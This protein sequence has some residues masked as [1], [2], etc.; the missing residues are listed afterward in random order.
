MT[1]TPFPP[2][3]P[4]A[5]PL[6]LTRAGS[7]LIGAAVVLA[8]LSGP[9]YR[10]GLANLRVALLA[11]ALG[12]VV[13]F[14]GTVLA[15][16]GLTVASARRMRFER[17]ASTLAVLVGVV[18]SAFLIGWIARGRSAP[19]I[20]DISTDLDDPPAF[21]AVLPLRAAAHAANSPVYASS[22][23]LPG[24]RIIQVADLQR[25]RYPDIRSLELALEPAA[26]LQ[27]AEHA[28]GR[29]GWRIDA[30]VPAE[31]RL[32]ATDHTV[33]FGFRDDIVVRVRPSGHGSRV[34]VRSESRVGLG[35][36]GTNA[37][38]VR[39]FLRELSRRS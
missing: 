28:A 32:E 25:A 17:I 6:R 36:A 29:L 31:G 12:A 26:A 38:R 23:R 30:Y 3:G 13:L 14:A 5:W 9:A 11:L 16:V 27:A 18:A 10:T 1:T 35:D 34:D 4:P 7:W 20:H 39:A 15:L 37:R 22:E 24:G 33:F 19:P 21:V 8:L 2:L